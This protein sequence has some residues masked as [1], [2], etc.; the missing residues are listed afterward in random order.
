MRDWQ[1]LSQGRFTKNII[2]FCLGDA[3]Q[4]VL[5]MMKIR[6]DLKGIK[7]FFDEEEQES[8]KQ[9]KISRLE[10]KDKLP[11]YVIGDM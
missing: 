4:E 9:R 8:Y 2:T 10:A 3:I 6:A 1:M 5:G 11:A 7:L